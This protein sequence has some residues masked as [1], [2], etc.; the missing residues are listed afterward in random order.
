MG[1]VG[2]GVPLQAGVRLRRRRRLL[3]AHRVAGADAVAPDLQLRL[4]CV[5]SSIFSESI[6]L[7]WGVANCGNTRTALKPAA[8]TD[9]AG[10]ILR[11]ASFQGGALKAGSFSDCHLP[12]RV[13]LGAAS[14]AQEARSPGVYIIGCQRPFSP[15]NNVAISRMADGSEGA[16]WSPPLLLT[17]VGLC[18]RALPV[19]GVTLF[20]DRTRL[21]LRLLMPQPYL[22]RAEFTAA[23]PRS[24][25]ASLCNSVQGAAVVLTM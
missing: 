22:H 15:D 24:D 8:A 16:E 19:Q 21:R 1:G 4:R 10:M 25:I 7:S 11:T 5:G 2:P 13:P 12:A 20:A 9:M 23:A 17:K 3:E 14:D 18:I 6:C